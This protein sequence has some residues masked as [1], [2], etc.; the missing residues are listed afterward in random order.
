MTNTPLYDTIII[1]GS[2]A[3][4]SAAMALGRSL[5]KVLM[6]DAGQPCNRQTPHSH[7]FLT[8][9][10][11][12]PAELAATSKEQV[13][14]YSTVEFQEDF[15]V[16]AGLIDTG[17]EVKTRS[18]RTFQGKK[19]LLAFGVKD[20][21]PDIPG[22]AEC[23]GISVIHCPYCHGYE[24]RGKKTGI[25]A[26]RDQAF[27]LAPLVRNLSDQVQIL[28]KEH[29][30]FSSEQV[31]ALVRNGIGF[32]EKE[33]AEI[34]HSEGKIQEVVFTDGSTET[35]DALY[36]E[37]PFSLPGNLTESLG[38]ELTDAG[39]IR[40]DQ[41]QQTNILGVYACGDCAGST[42]SVASAVASG[43]LAGAMINYKLATESF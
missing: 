2:Y 33:I 1:G 28:L 35:L 14:A 29:S 27:H 36:A 17:F 4:L 16:G 42:R 8:Q 19:L 31:K 37:I 20:E 22:L 41:F 23:W 7:N 30:N 18:G 43:N 40:V 38:C 15:V 13:L 25:W 12:T 21:L 24:V 32:V 11:V 10:G 5:R 3:G 34:R 26:T 9:D 39:K 6:L